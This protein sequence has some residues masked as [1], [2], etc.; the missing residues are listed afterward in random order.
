VRNSKRK[1]PAR[2]EW[3]RRKENE[4]KYIMRKIQSA[5]LFQ[6]LSFLPSLTLL[7]TDLMERNSRKSR[8]SYRGFRLE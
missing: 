6:Y 8:Q 3:R 4:Y 1:I 5:T 7:S 2:R